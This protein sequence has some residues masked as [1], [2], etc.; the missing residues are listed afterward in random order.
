MTLPVAAALWEASLPVPTAA[1][2]GSTTW[3]WV[4][5]YV[6][7]VSCVGGCVGVG[8]GDVSC[9]GVGVGVHVC[10]DVSCVGVHVCGGCELCGC[11]GVGVGVGVGVHVCGDVSCVGVHV[12]GGCEPYE[13]GCLWACV[14]VAQ[15]IYEY[16][17]HLQ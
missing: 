5:T 16:G 15:S 8:V 14:K 6:G 10:G 17:S 12:C 9:V 7:D 2:L 3:S 13:C 4:C 11:V 1:S